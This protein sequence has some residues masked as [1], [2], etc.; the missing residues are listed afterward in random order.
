MSEIKVNKISPAT[1]TAFTLGDSGDTFTVPSGA[2]ITNS[3]TATGFGGGKILQVQFVEKT[4]SFTSNA[5]TATLITG[6]TVDITPT[7]TTSKIFV[8]VHA[9]GSQHPGSNNMFCTLQR[10]S[11]PIH[12]GDA[13]SSRQ[14]ATFQLHTNNLGWTAS[15]GCAFLDPN[16][17]ADTTTAIT[18]KLMGQSENASV[19]WHI[20]RSHNDSD[21]NLHGRLASSI[22]LIELGPN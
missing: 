20:N 22:T 13:S 6:M 15:G 3:G 11:T 16:T 8:L 18:Y 19:Y 4:D 14:R 7:A 2:T 21:S 5:A 9:Q 10:D 17:P 12:I 1:G